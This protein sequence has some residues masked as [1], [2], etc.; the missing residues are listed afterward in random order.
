MIDTVCIIIYGMSPVAQSAEEPAV[1]VSDVAGG[2]P[3]PAAPA[4]PLP[5]G[6]ETAKLVGPRQ[7]I[8][9]ISPQ[10]LLPVPGGHWYHSEQ[11]RPQGLCH[12]HS[13][14]TH[15]HHHDRQ[16]LPRG[17]EVPSARNVVRVSVRV[18]GRELH[19]SESVSVDPKVLSISV[20]GHSEE[21][22]HR[23]GHPGR[24]GSQHTLES[25]RSR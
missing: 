14:G 6:P 23:E 19:G 3:T 12:P 22:D 9:S 15:E 21:S 11:Q 25:A 24:A 10:L 7:E 5:E 18:P 8:P 17:Q 2:P 20:A 4:L 1:S 16:H 13:S